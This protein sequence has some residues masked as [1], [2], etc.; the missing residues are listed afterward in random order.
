MFGYAPPWPN[1]QCI[2][3]SYEGGVG[4]STPQSPLELYSQ[5]VGRFS[6][7]LVLMDGGDSGIRDGDGEDMGIGSRSAICMRS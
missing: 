3:P 5:P 2:S 1:T 7:N 6:D 4:T